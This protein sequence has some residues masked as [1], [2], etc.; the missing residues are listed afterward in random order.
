MHVYLFH[1]GCIE[2]RVTLSSAHI[3]TKSKTFYFK[4][5]DAIAVFFLLFIIIIIFHFKC[6]ENQ[7]HPIKAC[8]KKN[9]SWV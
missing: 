2:R 8:K 1:I 5:A 9:L 6:Y 3:T 7:A 4:M